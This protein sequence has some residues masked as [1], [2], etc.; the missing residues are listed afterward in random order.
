MN[1]ELKKEAQKTEE[2]LQFKVIQSG[3]THF[4]APLDWYDL[5]GIPGSIR[6]IV[7]YI[8]EKDIK[9]TKI[10]EGDIVEFSPVGSTGVVKG[11]VKWHDKGWV[12]EHEGSALTPFGSVRIVG[13]IYEPRT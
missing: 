8:G 11:I 4:T 13:N 7:P 6:V 10:F 5:A 1:E 3:M 12:Y 2:R 9:G